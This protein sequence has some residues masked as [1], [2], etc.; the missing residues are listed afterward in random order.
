MW[1]KR[2]LRAGIALA[3]CVFV[4]TAL[5]PA[6]GSVDANER[7]K[8]LVEGLVET[9]AMSPAGTPFELTAAETAKIGTRQM[10]ERLGI[11][12]ELQPI[13]RVVIRARDAGKVLEVNVRD[14]D[15]V[16]S[17]KLLVRFETD[18]LQSTLLLRQSDRDAAEAELMLAMLALTRTEQLALKNIASAEQL[19]KAK[20]DVAVKTA[21]LQSLSAQADIAR[22]ALRNAEIR[23]PFNGTV[24][25]RLAEAGSRVGADGELLTLVDTSVLEAKVL[26]ATRDVPRVAL[27]QTAELEID[28]L[29]GQIVKGTVDR[30]SPVAED[31]TRF[32]AVYL[33]L[34]NR[35]GRLWGGMFASGSILLREKDGALVVPAI[36]LRRDESGYHVLKVQDGHLRRQTVA[37]GP[38]WNGGSLIEIAAGLKDGETILTAPLPELQPG[39][40]V[41]I[42]K[43][44]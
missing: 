11:S 30:I 6:R 33:R 36:A 23:A 13:T 26:V 16:P 19:D 15:A 12:G 24:T 1:V 31:G 27:G 14:G 7:V 22:L 8:G 42:D 32:V 37:V 43:A 9:A 35:D 2:T 40:A 44:G 28:G 10:V 34:A 3:G 5:D 29:G 4:V 25:R 41:A 38:H 39:M 18:E 17:G 21:R 20:S